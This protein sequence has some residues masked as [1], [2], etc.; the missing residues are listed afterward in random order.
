MYFQ[1]VHGLHSKDVK[2]A[3]QSSTAGG[4]RVIWM[5]RT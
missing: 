2:P 4:R 3:E 5:P 1:K